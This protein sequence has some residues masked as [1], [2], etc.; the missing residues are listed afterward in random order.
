MFKKLTYNFIALILITTLFLVLLFPMLGFT[1]GINTT[2]F[3]AIEIIFI[4]YFSTY[5]Q[6]KILLLFAVGILVD[7]LLSIPMGISSTAFILANTGLNYVNK[8]FMLKDYIVNLVVFC[9]YTLLIFYLRY[10]IISSKNQG[11]VIM[12]EFV[13]QYLLTVFCYPLVRPILNLACKYL[14]RKDVK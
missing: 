6:A 11:S 8:W 5:Y 14:V 12:V 9:C 7:Q 1:L 10:L 3:P 4:Y 13:F 2:I